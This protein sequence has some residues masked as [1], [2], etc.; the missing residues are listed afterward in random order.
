MGRRNFLLTLAYD[1][2]DFLGWQRL[3]GAGRSVQGA[4]EEALSSIL[5]E[6][7]EGRT[8]GRIEVV[9]AGRTD[10]GVH[11]EGQ[12]ASFH[13]RTALSPQAITEALAAALPPD[14]AC[15]SCREVDPR[16]HA[17]FRA[18]AKVYRYRLHVGR[19][20]DP[21]SR[22]TSFHVPGPLDLA[23][24]QAAGAELLGEHDFRALSNAKGG[25]T[26]RRL[27][28]VRVERKGDFVDLYFEGPGFLYNQV[29]IMASVLLETGSGR[30]GPGG[31]AAILASK[32]RSRAPGAL[33]AYGLCLVEVKY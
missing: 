23:A 19:V 6:S 15:V 14:L 29:R 3:P 31:A 4:V 27:D 32:D 9:G 2:T 33:G 25:D 7:R 26:L 8:E 1:G 28:S 21:R 12:A 11:A 13:S 16:F 5:G 30:L 20:P 10:A 18:K 24:M 17:R 22:R